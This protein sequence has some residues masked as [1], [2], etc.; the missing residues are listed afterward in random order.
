MDMRLSALTLTSRNLRRSR[1]FYIA[2]LGF[3][4][5]EE[6]AGKMFVVDAG[7]IRLH[8]DGDG[9]RPP[10]DLAEPRLLFRTTEL[11]ERCHALRDAGVSVEG[12]RDGV[13]RLSDPDGHP[14]ILMEN[15]T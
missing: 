7:G 8:V 14:I 9:T 15:N 4:L 5:V 12:P 1:A 6:R 3:K 10:L 11:N 2:K 13:A